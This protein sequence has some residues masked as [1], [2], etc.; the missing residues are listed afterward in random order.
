MNEKTIEQMVA[1]TVLEKPLDVKV[2]EKTYQS[3]TQVRRHL[4]LFQRLS[5]NFPILCLTPKRSLKKPCPWR[6]TA[7]F[8]AT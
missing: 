6:K 4:F 8:S 2:G 1:E 7:V 5:R 3:P